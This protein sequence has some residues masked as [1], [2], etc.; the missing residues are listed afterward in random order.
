MVDEPIWVTCA[1]GR[2]TKLIA[3]R[4]DRS[5]KMIA[6]CPVCLAELEKT[7]NPY[8]VEM[9]PLESKHQRMDG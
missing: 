1:C 6:I 2:L 3:F 8:R 5:G 4:L 7:K 9:R